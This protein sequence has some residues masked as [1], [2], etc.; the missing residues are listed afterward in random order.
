MHVDGAL[1]GVGSHQLPLELT[2]SANGALQ[3]LLDEDSLLWVD[4]L[5]VTLLQLPVD[6]DVLD[7][8]ASQMLEGLIL[9]PGLHLLHAVF[10]LLDWHVLHFD[11]LLQVVHGILQL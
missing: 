1:S 3:S 9:G 2:N 11:L 5:I 7:I 6:V 8:Q 4:H 10:V